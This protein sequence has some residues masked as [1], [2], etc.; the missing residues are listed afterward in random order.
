MANIIITS[1]A[2]TMD[3]VFNDTSSE[4]GLVKG[5]FNRSHISEVAQLR[6]GG[7]IIAMVAAHGV[8]R[9]YKVSYDGQNGARVDTLGGVA[10]TG[11]RQLCDLIGAL[12]K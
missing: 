1:T 4:F 10:I 5:C 11:D 7:V 6:D 9:N 12:I 8:S 3:I 2:N